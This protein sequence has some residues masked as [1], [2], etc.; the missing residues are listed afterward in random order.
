MKKRLAMLGQEPSTIIRDAGAGPAMRRLLTRTIITTES[1]VKP[2]RSSRTAS[3]PALASRQ[4]AVPLMQQAFSAKKTRIRL[5]DHEGEQQGA[6]EI[7]TGVMRLFR[8]GVGHRLV[9]T[10]TQER[11]LQFV[12]MADLLLAMISDASATAPRAAADAVPPS[13]AAT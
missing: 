2:A 11:A 1:S 5:S 9:G 4:N 3:A 6:M 7:Y 10:I 12:V 13:E 8:N